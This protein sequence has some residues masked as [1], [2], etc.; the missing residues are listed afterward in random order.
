ML[1]KTISQLIFEPKSFF[2]K[3]AGDLPSS[4][5]FLFLVLT[6]ILDALGFWLLARGVVLGQWNFRFDLIILGLGAL[7]AVWLLF[8]LA[9]WI[10]ARIAG[11]RLGMW[12]LVKAS[13]YASMPFTVAWVPALLGGIAKT[14][15]PSVAVKIAVWL[16][17]AFLLNLSLRALAAA[18]KAG[19]V[20]AGTRREGTQVSRRFGI[21]MAVPVLAAIAI[22]GVG[23]GLRYHGDAYM[24]QGNIIFGQVRDWQVSTRGENMLLLIDAETPEGLAPARMAV[25]VDPLEAGESIDTFFSKFESAQTEGML[26][27][28]E[29]IDLQ[30]LPAR[31]GTIHLQQGD[32]SIVLTLVVGDH[33]SYL[34]FLAGQA[35]G[36]DAERASG[37]YQEIYQAMQPYDRRMHVCVPGLL[38]W[39][40]YL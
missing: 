2:G 22:L 10:V 15:A 21:A 27:S 20:K 37:R 7:A 29:N 31:R 9:V 38:D 4:L 5:P 12:S 3:D 19:F 16:L 35:Q 39:N 36:T 1:T 18:V 40:Y 25:E 11:L 13:A 24:I 26:V 32:L 14:G 17:M 33:G 23:W 8:T 28:S 6:L 34:V 30:G